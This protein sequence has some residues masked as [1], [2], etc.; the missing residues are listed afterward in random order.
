MYKFVYYI[1]PAEQ[2]RHMATL[3]KGSCPQQQQQPS[4]RYHIWHKLPS[5]DIKSDG[6]GAHL[7]AVYGVNRCHGNWL[8]GSCLEGVIP[9]AVIVALHI[10][11]A[12]DAVADLQLR[13][14]PHKRFTLFSCQ[15]ES[16]Q[17]GRQGA[18][19]GFEHHLKEGKTLCIHAVCHMKEC[20]AH[21]VVASIVNSMPL[22]RLLGIACAGW[23][24]VLHQGLRQGVRS[25]K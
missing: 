11:I 10:E 18:T 9:A 7:A 8:G 22:K 20:R 17:P 4:I 3:A 13:S 19:Q 16:Q 6:A 21:P 25:E 2:T 14:Q 5:Y 12:V 23:I 15:N 1:S 24:W